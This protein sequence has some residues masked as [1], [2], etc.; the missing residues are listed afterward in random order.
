L[1]VVVTAGPTREAID[2]VRYLSNHSSG[3]MGYAIARAARAAGATVILVSGPVALPPPAGVTV[4]SVT[5]AAEMCAAVLAAIPGAHI[6]I[7]AAAVA[8]Y[9]LA[10]PAPQ[11]IKKDLA[12]LSLTLEATTDI[13]KTVAQ[14]PKPPFT[15]GFAA[16]TADLAANAQKKLKAKALH[17]IAANWIGTGETGFGT[18]DNA[19]H[20][21][22]P[23]GERAFPRASKVRLGE[24]LVQL[25]AERYREQSG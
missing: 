22:W 1:T 15:V 8:D 17:M 5:T 9:R 16:E 11:K 21:F 19:L 10:A 20:C 12:S 14:L 4:R 3:R 23:G 7:A 25:I 6:L 24:D 2:P 13:L 18:E